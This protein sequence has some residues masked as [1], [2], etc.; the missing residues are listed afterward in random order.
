MRTGNGAPVPS[1]GNITQV[2]QVLEGA[3]MGEPTIGERIRAL[4]KPPTPS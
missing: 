1:A 4:R 3:G 2:S